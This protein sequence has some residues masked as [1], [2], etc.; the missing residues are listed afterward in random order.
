MKNNLNTQGELK[1]F[2][3]LSIVLS[4]TVLLTNGKIATD[5][6]CV[7]RSKG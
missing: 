1:M 7:A 4:A 2:T 3:M 5:V 6:I